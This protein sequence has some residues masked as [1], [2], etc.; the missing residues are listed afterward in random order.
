MNTFYMPLP[1]KTGTPR[2]ALVA[3]ELAHQADLSLR[4]LLGWLRGMIRNGLQARAVARAAAQR[5]R[6]AMALRQFA[7]QVMQH[8]TRFAADLLAAAERHEAT[9]ETARGY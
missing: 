5:N 1:R 2:G 4:K 3:A 8:D 9:T 7:R 6:D